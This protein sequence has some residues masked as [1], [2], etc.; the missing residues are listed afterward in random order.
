MDCAG[1]LRGRNMDKKVHKA[2]QILKISVKCQMKEL[3]GL[4]VQHF[5]PFIKS[6]ADADAAED[7]ILERETIYKVLLAARKLKLDESEK[8]V[9]GLIPG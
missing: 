5:T 4:I 9:L 2:L 6:L 8:V 7:L 3:T 1:D